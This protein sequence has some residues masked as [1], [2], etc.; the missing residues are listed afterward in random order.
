MMDGSHPLPALQAPR[1]FALAPR[2]DITQRPS[3]QYCSLLA[4]LLGL[5]AIATERT[6]RLPWDQATAPRCCQN[7]RSGG[8]KS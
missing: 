1:P 4:M 2:R 8:R 7:V 3:E 6:R 5:C